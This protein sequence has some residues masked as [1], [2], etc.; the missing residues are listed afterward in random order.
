MFIKAYLDDS[1]NERSWVD[2]EQCR[3]FVQYIVAAFNTKIIPFSFESKV[4]KFIIFKELDWAEEGYWCLESSWI[5]RPYRCFFCRFSI[6]GLRYDHCWRLILTDYIWILDLNEDQNSNSSSSYQQQLLTKAN[7]LSKKDNL[8]KFQTDIEYVVTEY[9]KEQLQKRLI[10]ENKNLI[11]LLQITCGF[12]AI[13]SFSLSK[14]ET[15]LINPKLHV[16][17][18][19]LLLAVC[20]NCTKGD[21]TDQELIVQLVKLKPKH[22]YQQHYFDCI[23]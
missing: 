18:Q 12:G 3:D 10:V 13:R 22:K 20:V 5:H 23:R 14:I 2:N 8:K 11:K 15:W 4:A 19:D 9:I 1:L 7:N 17:A 21:Q 16:Y 6:N